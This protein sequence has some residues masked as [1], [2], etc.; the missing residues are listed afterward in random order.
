[1]RLDSLHAGLKHEFTYVVPANRTVPN[2]FPES[3]EFAQMPR[4]LATGY[5]VGL[6]EWACMQ[7]VI[8]YLDLPNEQTV[9]THIDLSHEAPTPPGLEIVCRVELTGIQGRRLAFRVEVEDG[10]DIVARGTH[11]RHVIDAGAF[12]A[13]AF[14][15]GSR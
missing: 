7:L 11:E 14:A 6:V 8:P 9:G 2:L 12:E 10:V 15:K 5:L 4:V 13:R 1:M 3:R